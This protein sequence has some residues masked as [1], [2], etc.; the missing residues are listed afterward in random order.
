MRFRKHGFALAIGALVLLLIL[1]VAGIS[2]F[3]P[4]YE[5]RFF[6]L[7]LLGKDKTAESYFQ[8]GN[9][10][11]DVSSKVNWYIYVYNH[12]G[13]AQNVDVKVKLINSTMELPDDREHEPSLLEALVDFPLSLSVNETVF[14]PFSWSILEADYQNGSTVL[15][16]L[17][18][19]DQM[20]EVDVPVSSDSSFYIVFE[21]WVYD[22]VSHEYKFGWGSE[23]GFFSA[24]LNMGF[25]VNLPM[26]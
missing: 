10:T 15:K 20:V 3:W 2:A 24:S 14:V 5:E 19:N 18:V 6:E 23:K 1:V 4:S 7:G 25:R 9:S 12:M 17:M 22:Q 21:L 26:A 16:R 11:L 13:N 8:E